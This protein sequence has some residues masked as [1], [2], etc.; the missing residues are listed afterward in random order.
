MEA[1][2]SLFCYEQSVN[3]LYPK[4]DESSPKFHILFP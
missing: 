2:A 4:P 1:E 3:S